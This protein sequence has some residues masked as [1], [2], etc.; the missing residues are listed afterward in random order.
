MSNSVVIKKCSSEDG[1]TTKSCHSVT[2]VIPVRN[3]AHAKIIRASLQADPE[4][5]RSYCSK[6]IETDN[7]GLKVRITCDAKFDSSTN[8]KNLRNATTSFFEL[9]DLLLQTIDQ[10]SE[11]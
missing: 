5:E 3:V 8:I 7:G 1:S 9:L 6:V 10:F 4:P 11:N 2:F